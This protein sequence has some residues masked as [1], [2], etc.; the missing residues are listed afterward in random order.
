[1]NLNKFKKRLIK[2]WQEIPPDLVRAACNSFFVRMRKII[3][4]KGERFE[5]VNKI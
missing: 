4:I 5:K 2:I 1:M 3:E